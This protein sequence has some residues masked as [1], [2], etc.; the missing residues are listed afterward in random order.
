MNNNKAFPAP[1]LLEGA[2]GGENFLK[3]NAMKIT[4]ID[5]SRLRNDEHFQFHTNFKTLVSKAGAAA[6]NVQPQFE[7]Y[8][9]LYAQ[10]DEALK[11]IMKSAITAD[12]QDADKQRDLLFRGM[13]DANKSALNHFNPAVREAAKRLKIVFDTYGNLAQKPL[14]EETSGIYNL[15]QD[16]N[17][18]YAQDA[19]TA[20][21]TDWMAELGASNAAFDQLTI[22]RYEESG[23]KTDLVMKECRKAV[24][25][26]Y[27]A[28]IERINAYAL[29]AADAAYADFIPT[30][31]AVIEKYSNT[32]EQRRGAT[33]T[34][35]GASTCFDYAQQPKL[36]HR[37]H[38]E[39]RSDEATSGSL[40]EAETTV[41][42]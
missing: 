23:M 12:I 40:S 6:L 18:K 11:K 31:N 19:A 24:D 34:E 10:E 36:S 7:A 38:C 28:L 8:L 37:R 21:L 39:E 16:L 20:G 27:R 29:I 17:G 30:F 41:N 26:A 35:S 42:N 3:N 4:K 5:A 13:T 32:V 22:A 33:Q 9:T 1:P 2:G 14:N 15:L 25:E